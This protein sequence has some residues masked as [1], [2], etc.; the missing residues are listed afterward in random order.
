MRTLQGT[1][2]SNKMAKTLV[3]QIHRYKA[4]SK[5]KKRYRISKKF[6]V[7]DP[8]E[9]HKVDDVVTFYESKPLSRLKRWTVVKPKDA[10]KAATP[11]KSEPKAET[12]APETKP[13]AISSEPSHS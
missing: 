8:Q 7:D 6:Y 13:E 3:V 1:V 11:K 5:Y 2:V 9:K 4:H 10:A 12:P